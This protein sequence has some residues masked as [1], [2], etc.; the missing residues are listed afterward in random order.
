[1]ENS[2][3][4]LGAI[5]RW[6]DG[7]SWR[8]AR[9]QSLAAC[10]SRR[11][12]GEDPL[13]LAAQECILHRGRPG[14]GEVI[15]AARQPAV[16]AAVMLW[17]SPPAREQITI[18]LIAETP[19]ERIAERMNLPKKIIETAR[20][21]FFDLGEAKGTVNFG[22]YF[23]IRAT[24]REGN[25]ELAGKLRLAH[26]G[27]P[28]LAEALLDARQGIPVS[29]AERWFDQLLLL[30]TK[31]QEAVALPLGSGD[32]VIR[33]LK[34]NWEIQFKT[35]RL[36]LEREK[37]RHKREMELRKQ[38]LAEDLAAEARTLA[39]DAGRPDARNDT[40]GEPRSPRPQATVAGKTAA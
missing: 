33:L 37:F 19:I 9:A 27:G 15:A 12:E 2:Q 10:P 18:L 4:A 16:H 21:L 22:A 40:E 35:Q 34:L 30:H 8:W 5:L 20:D 6:S 7:V 13:I 11:M 1:M 39:A 26:L 38:T 3:Q 25:T 29:E 31:V 32:N 36:E 23:F 24:E 14:A 28:L 17:E